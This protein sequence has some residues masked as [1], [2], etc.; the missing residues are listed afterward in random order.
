MQVGVL[1]WAL[2]VLALAS[3][4]CLFV[5]PKASPW[6]IVVGQVVPALVVM[7][8]WVLPFD[9]LMARVFMA[10]RPLEQ[11]PRLKAVIKFDLALLALLAVFWGPY[12]LAVLQP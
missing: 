11:Q 7:V 2:A 3:L 1:R 6:T 4:V 9:A 12:F 10:D 5:E 8:A